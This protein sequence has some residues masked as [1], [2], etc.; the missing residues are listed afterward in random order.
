[1][2]VG[3]NQHRAANNLG[4]RADLRNGQSLSDVRQ[5]ILPRASM[6]AAWNDRQR[7]QQGKAT[8]SHGQPF[9]FDLNGHHAQNAPAPQEASLNARP[10]YDW[11]LDRSDA[12]YYIDPVGDLPPP[13]LD[14][15]L[16]P[17]TIRPLIRLEDSRE[18]R[19]EQMRSLMIGWTAAGLL[20]V[21][22]L[23]AFT[24]AAIRLPAIEQQLAHNARI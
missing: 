14:P 21:L 4:L 2:S 15:H 5:R 1:M 11:S 10:A 20:A 17:V 8:V 16:V 3:D 13:D 19:M 22:A 23:T 24:A 12:A 6:G 7:E 18:T 9:S